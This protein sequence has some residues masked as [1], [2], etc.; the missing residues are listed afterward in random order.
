MTIFAMNTGK[1][2]GL[3]YGDGHATEVQFRIELAA[4]MALGT[5]ERYEGELLAEK[6]QLETTKPVAPA[7]IATA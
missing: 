7:S 6:T 3:G 4:A 1:P 5:L 2:A